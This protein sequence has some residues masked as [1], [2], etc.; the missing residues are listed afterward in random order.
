MNAAGRLKKIKKTLD[1][2]HPEESTFQVFISEFGETEEQTLKRYGITNKS[3]ELQII[4]I[5][6]VDK[7][8][9]FEIEE[10]KKTSPIDEEINLLLDE[11][12]DDGFSMHE[13][14]S[15][16]APDDQN[17]Q[18]IIPDISSL[19]NRRGK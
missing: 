19:F 17:I 12:A 18:P 8:N 7:K 15:M 2:K 6:F 3:K 14:A 9:Q 1:L 4:I 11:L 5:K 16:I 10:I 13:I